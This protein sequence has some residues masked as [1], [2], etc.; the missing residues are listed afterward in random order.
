MVYRII[1]DNAAAMI[2]AYKFDVVVTDDAFSA[3]IR[4]LA[5]S[6]P[7][8]IS[9]KASMDVMTVSS[10]RPMSGTCSIPT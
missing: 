1:T 3:T 6:R 2:E 7:I 10:M 4:Q 5:N 8:R 9:M